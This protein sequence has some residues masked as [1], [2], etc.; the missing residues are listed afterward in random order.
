MLSAASVHSTVMVRKHCYC[1]AASKGQESG[2]ANL[3][4]L[5]QDLFQI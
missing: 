3:K 5:A 1:D 4:S 2:Y